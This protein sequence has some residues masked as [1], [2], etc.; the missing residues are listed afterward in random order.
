MK[1]RS[2]SGRGDNGRGGRRHAGRE[3]GMVRVMRKRQE[4]RRML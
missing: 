4:G 1:G 3:R 2:E